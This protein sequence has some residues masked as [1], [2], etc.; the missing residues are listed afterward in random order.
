MKMECSLVYRACSTKGIAQGEEI[1][2]R[3]WE[4][5]SLSNSPSKL[6][7]TMTSLFLQSLQARKVSEFPAT[8]TSILFPLLFTLPKAMRVSN[9]HPQE[10]YLFPCLRFFPPHS[11]LHTSTLQPFFYLPSRGSS[12][13]TS[14]N[15]P[16]DS[17]AGYWPLLMHH[18]QSFHSQTVSKL[19]AHYI[20]LHFS[21]HSPLL[22]S[23]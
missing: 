14:P 23:V 17:Y 13:Y 8:C 22:I 9:I 21:L 19:P 6:E 18:L 12:I 16:A 4:F 20:N 1:Q 5:K 15:L 7:P 10:D 2:H 11:P 3:D